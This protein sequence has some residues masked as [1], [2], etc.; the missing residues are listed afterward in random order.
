MAVMARD[1]WTDERL[2]DLN[3][4]MDEGFRAT[5]EEFRSLR[6]EVGEEFRSLRSETRE[7]FTAVR[8]ELKGMREETREGFIALREEIAADRR[9]SIQVAWAA[10]A[11]TLVGFLGVI[12]T[13]LATRT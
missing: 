7:E 5:G 11:T 9:V 6:T 8:D 10:W 4:R 3:H 1:S 12:A 13:I 2:D